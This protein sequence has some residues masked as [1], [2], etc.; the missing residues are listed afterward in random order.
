MSVADASM[1][2]MGE[3]GGDAMGYEVDLVGDFDGVD[4]MT[5]VQGRSV[6]APTGR[7]R[8]VLHHHGCGHAHPRGPCSL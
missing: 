5:S 2:W 1:A 6:T 7:E 4:A 3:E 8:Q